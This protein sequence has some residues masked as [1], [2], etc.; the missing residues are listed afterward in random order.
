MDA[1]LMQEIHAFIK[2]IG[3]VSELECTEAVKFLNRFAANYKVE[4]NS[5]W[6]WESLGRTSTV[7]QYGD[8]DGLEIIKNYIDGSSIVYF[9]VT[10]DEFYPWPVFKGPLY[11]FMELISEQR[12]FEYFLVDIEEEWCIFDTHHNSLIMAGDIGKD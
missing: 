8:D 12:I 10:D 2:D 9:V 3:G 1:E 11:R 6:W 7:I 5:R 4:V